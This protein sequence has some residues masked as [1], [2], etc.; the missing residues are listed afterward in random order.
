[1][2]TRIGDLIDALGELAPWELAEEWDNPGLQVGDRE[3]TVETVSV[4]L[5]PAPEEVDEALMTG[6]HL[7]VTHHPLIFH[8]M[9]RVD[10]GES[11]AR[12]LAR[13]IR[14]GLAWFPPTPISTQPRGGWLISSPP[15]LD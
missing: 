2:A 9:R 3:A 1:M 15:D 8:P 13:I 6:A 4:A 11:E 5:D 7:L 10:L 14:G 12:L